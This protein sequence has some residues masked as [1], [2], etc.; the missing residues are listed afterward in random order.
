MADF[1]FN[2]RSN[3]WL[4]L[5]WRVARPFVIGYLIVLLLMMLLEPWLVYPRPPL[6]LGNWNPTGL[7]HDEVWFKSGDGTR[8]HGWLVAHAEPKYAIVYCHGNGEHIALNANLAAKLRDTLQAT[9]FMF[10][11]RGYGHSEG[12]PSESGCIADGSAAQHWLAK[13]LSIKS[14]QVVLMGRSL[15]SAVALAAAAQNGARALILENGFTSMPE[16]A[17]L[18]YPF[19]PVRFA[20]DNRYECLGW[21]CQYQGPIFQTHGEADELMPLD[22]SCQLFDASPSRSK[23]WVSFP[24]LGHNSP[25]PD[26]YYD[27]LANFLAQSCR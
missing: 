27:N 22:M 14:N 24:G 20:M 16:I 21:I 23:R 6:E 1:H 2:R 5:S 3:G 7:E 4:R 26:S 17:A 19:L 12:S 18:H 9:V 11:Y 10:D 13:R 8:L 15:G 25:W